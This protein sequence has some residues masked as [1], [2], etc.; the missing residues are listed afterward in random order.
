MRAR[1]TI[2]LRGCVPLGCL[3]GG[4]RSLGSAAIMASAHMTPAR[5]VAIHAAHA[6]R[7][8]MASCSPAAVVAG[9]A[10]ARLLARSAVEAFNIS[11]ERLE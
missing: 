6:N 8:T 9:A 11:A 10:H 7:L 1:K 3:L 4:A 2:G 5:P